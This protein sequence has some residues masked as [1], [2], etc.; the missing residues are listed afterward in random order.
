MIRWA[1]FHLSLCSKIFMQELWRSQISWDQ[2]IPE[3][4]KARWQLIYSKLPYLNE[5]SIPRWTKFHSGNRIE[6]HGFADASTHA[7]AAVVYL[8]TFSV[9]G[10]ITV[11]LLAS[12]SKVVPV[13]PLTIPRLE[14]SAAL[15]LSQLMLF[16][17]NSLCLNSAPVFLWTDSTIVLTRVR[18]FPM[19]HIRG[20]SRIQNSNLPDEAWRY[21]PT[22]SNPADCASRGLH[23]DEL[24]GHD[25]WW[26]GPS[27]LTSDPI[28]WPSELAHL[29]S[30][31]PRGDR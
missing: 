25:L 9:S 4:L 7:Y 28:E 27:W 22:S 11:S 16:V 29:T 5:V 20:Q 24:L 23:P 19:D 3:S 21:V 18:S 1:G 30:E 12:K 2:S 26:R 31:P 14:L 6:V 15:V 10:N 8:K 13:S 17:R